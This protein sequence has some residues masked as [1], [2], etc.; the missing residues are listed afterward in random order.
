VKGR[1]DVVSILLSVVGAGS[2]VQQAG[3][4]LARH[5]PPTLIHLR[6]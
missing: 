5:H 1:G 6:V 4:P 3:L 2:A